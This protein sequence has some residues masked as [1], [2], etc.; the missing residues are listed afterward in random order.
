MFWIRATERTFK[1]LPEDHANCSVGSMTQGLLDLNDA[2]ARGDVALLLES[3][4][5]DADVVPQIPVVNERSSAIVY[6]PL[7]DCEIDPDV[8]FL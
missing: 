7:G 8:V 5:V 2:A 3:G 6:G 4:W 1:T